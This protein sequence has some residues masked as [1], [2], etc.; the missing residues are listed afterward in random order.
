MA[1]QTWLAQQARSETIDAPFESPLRNVGPNEGK[2]SIR[3]TPGPN[4]VIGSAGQKV[5]YW[6]VGRRTGETEFHHIT[7][8]QL[9]GGVN[10]S[11][12]SR[13]GYWGMV[14]DLLGGEYDAVKA[15][16]YTVNGPITFGVEGEILNASR[17]KTGR[18]A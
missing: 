3:I 5:E 18:A 17:P 13:S 15:F 7:G 8:G 11:G 16:Y 9:E 6:A 4:V 2:I 14:L 10:P 12:V 1:F